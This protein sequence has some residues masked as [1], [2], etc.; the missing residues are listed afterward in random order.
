MN[1]TTKKNFLSINKVNIAD[2]IIFLI[3][4]VGGTI[5]NIYQASTM[6]WSSGWED[7]LGFIIGWIALYFGVF[8]ALAL[9]KKSKH[10][11]WILL[12]EAMLY[13]VY[14]CLIS[15]WATGILNAV[16]IPLILLFSH[17]VLW[18]KTN[19]ANEKKLETRKFTLKNGLIIVSG[20]LILSVAISGLLILIGVNESKDW[21]K[22]LWYMNIWMDGM[23]ASIGFFA[24]LLI[25]LRFKENFFLFLLS[26]ILKLVLFI[27]TISVIKDMSYVLSI[28]FAAGY[29]LNALYGIYIWNNGKL[30]KSLKSLIKN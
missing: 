7:I 1:A 20:T 17:F 9:S 18:K 30:E 24:F 27:A 11:W 10:S 25:M 19:T 14:L 16:I 15:T 3:I 26:N 8:G 28:I 21:P 13:G 22:W 4:G 2:I 29:L 12:I 23:I 5:F 6:N